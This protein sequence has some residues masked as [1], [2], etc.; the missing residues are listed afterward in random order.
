MQEGI[1]GVNLGGWLVLEKWMA[2]SVFEGV[3]GP[4]EY[5]LCTE[6]GDEAADRLE[7]HRETFIQESDIA[8]LAQHGI[9]AVRLPVP[10]W[11]FDGFEPFTP[12]KK[13]IDRVF[14]WTQA[15]KLGVVLDLHTAPGS[16]NGEHHSGKSG[17]IRWGRDPGTIDQTLD[18]I[19]RFAS[20]YGQEPNLIGIELINEPGRPKRSVPVTT[21]EFYQ[22]GYKRVRRHA[23]ADVAVIISDSYRPFDWRAKFPNELQKDMIL[24]THLYQVFGLMDKALT[25]QGHI[26]KA[27]RRKQELE[28]ISSQLGGVMIG[29]WS[30]ALADRARH[31]LNSST[32]DEFMKAFAEA[33]IESYDTANMGWF[34]WTYKMQYGG[35][36][37][38]RDCVERGWLELNKPN[39]AVRI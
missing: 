36:W 16:Q 35:G 15:H 6:L 19:E 14:K 28:V 22:E 10:H 1:R 9:N 33:Q 5:S 39:P 30:L 24:D 18:V 29:E 37:N 26:E 4:D 32:E 7:E 12:C 27:H 21:L 11:A 23:R 13:Y 38:F 8:W 31:S 17:D 3:Q 34:F 25:T 2:P 20:H